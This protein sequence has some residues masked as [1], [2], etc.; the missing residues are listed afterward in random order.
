MGVFLH[1]II[2]YAHNYICCCASFSS[3]KMLILVQLTQH[4]WSPLLSIQY[5]FERIVIQACFKTLRFVDIL[6]FGRSS[7]Q[8]Y[9]YL[10]FKKVVFPA[11]Y[12]TGWNVLFQSCLLTMYTTVVVSNLHSQGKHK[13]S[14]RL[15][16]CHTLRTELFPVENST[17]AFRSRNLLQN[18]KLSKS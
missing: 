16:I 18:L 6:S 11:I 15:L 14:V 2:N 9:I 17:P 3:S 1:F 8:F 7:F 4:F 12:N 10:R 5:L 13:T